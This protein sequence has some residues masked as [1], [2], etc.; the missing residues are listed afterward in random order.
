M[1]YWSALVVALISLVAMAQAPEL[2]E[3]LK[4]AEAGDKDQQFQAGLYYSS[5]TNGFRDERQALTWFTK[6]AEQG[7]VEAQF[8]AASLYQLGEQIERDYQKAVDWYREAAKSS[9]TRAMYNLG[10][11]YVYGLGLEKDYFAAGYWLQRAA[12]DDHS[13]AQVNLGVLMEKGLGVDPDLDTTLRL[14]GAAAYAGDPYAMYNLGRFYA[15][16]ISVEKDY[17]RAFTLYHLAA[18]QGVELAGKGRDDLVPLMDAGMLSRAKNAARDFGEQMDTGSYEGI[19][20]WLALPAPEWGVVAERY[21]D[22]YQAPVITAAVPAKQA[23]KIAPVATLQPVPPK[24]VPAKPAPAPVSK[25]VTQP[26][27][28]QPAATPKPVARV[29]FAQGQDWLRQQAGQ[30]YTLQ[31]AVRN[32]AQDVERFY[33]TYEVDTLGYYQVKGKGLYGIVYGSFTSKQA[34]LAAVAQLAAPLRS[35]KPRAVRIAAIQKRMQ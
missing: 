1:R 3:I 7:H 24:P 18:R 6:A 13:N 33:N 28:P 2:E 19:R 20:E 21:G 17:E 27:T 4:Q 35:L 29:A 25:P 15:E 11:S 10:M 22:E 9:H 12:R 14:F 31:L 23:P 30:N 16:A 8:N 26:V 32:S 34:A 5:P